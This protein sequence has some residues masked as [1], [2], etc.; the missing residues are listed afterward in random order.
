MYI[1]FSHPL[2]LVFL[3]A[4]PILIFLHFFSLRSRRRDSLKF[5]NFDAI[6]R[7][8]GIDLYSKNIFKLVVDIL[9]VVI[10]VFAL[11]GLSLHNEVDAS[12]FSFVIAIDSSQSMTA[13]DMKPNRL[14]AAKESAINFVD[15]LPFESYVGVLSFSGESIA[16][17]KLTKDKLLLK[18]AIDDI[19]IN[20][21]GGTDIY[22]AVVNSAKMLKGERNKAVILL[23]DGQVNVGSIQDAIDYARDYNVMVHTIGIGS[24]EGGEVSYGMS[25]LD[26]DSL[27]SLAYNT[28]GSYFNVL[29]KEELKS[30]FWEIVGVTQKLAE[31]ELS[32]YLLMIVVVLFVV[33][34][35]WGGMTRMGW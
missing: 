20:M 2:Y 15:G 11:S 13:V 21:V 6:A 3:F 30:S 35:F 16:E 23:S 27:K 19:E 29:D 14:E 26:E 9:F 24:V 17:Q 28:G 12:S 22:E 18:N 5:A 8:K 32:F 34:E 7:V 31:I 25:K 4:I 33:R 10:L 1:S